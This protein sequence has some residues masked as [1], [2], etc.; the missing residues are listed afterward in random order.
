V[1]LRYR[2]DT[3]E[4]LKGVSVC[5]P[6]GARVGVVGRTGAG[7]TSLIAA[8]LRTAD[9]QSG[10]ITLDAV[11]TA[12]VP[13]TRLRGV[14]SYVP[15]EAVLFTGSVRKNLDVLGQHS[16]AGGEERLWEALRAVGLVGGATSGAA[17]ID[18]LEGT[19]VG[20]GGGNFSAGERQLICIAR[21]MLKRARVVV[22]DEATASVDA[23]GDELV[24]AALRKAFE[25]AT[26]LVVAHRI[27]TVLDS[28]LIL[29]MQDGRVA[30]FGPPQEL[31]RKGGLFRDL[32]EE[33]SAK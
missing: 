8:L 2:R 16:G 18:S 32:V 26:T 23:A 6:A 21:A 11:D 27:N 20:E 30:E 25:G 13:R 1:C 33:S 3:P 24:Q 7:K 9:V 5:I 17:R 31:L 14:I 12:S 28:D 15:Q 19:Q 10:S 22:M 29:C 4:V